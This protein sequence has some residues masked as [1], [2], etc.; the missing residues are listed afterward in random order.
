MTPIRT[1]WATGARNRAMWSW[2]GSATLVMA[3]MRTTRPVQTPGDRSSDRRPSPVVPSLGPQNEAPG[4]SGGSA[5]KV[6]VVS[7]PTSMAKVCRTESLNLSVEEMGSDEVEPGAYVR[8]L[9]P[10][11]SRDGRWTG[12]KVRYIFVYF[13]QRC[14]SRALAKSVILNHFDLFGR[15][16]P[17]CTRSS[18]VTDADV[19]VL[20]LRGW[21]VDVKDNEQE[22]ALARSV[23]VGG[24]T[25]PRCIKRWNS[26]HIAMMSASICTNCWCAIHLHHEHH[27][28]VLVNGVRWLQ[29]LP[30]WF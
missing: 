29:W 18:K 9:V 16:F 27:K 7:W 6:L 3:A 2:S 20:Q 10:T 25:W 24:H 28:S 13:C 22:E 21:Q 5:N 12:V 1:W 26:I 17:G 14:C 8:S 11:L 19:R 30:A 15:T 23:K 4:R